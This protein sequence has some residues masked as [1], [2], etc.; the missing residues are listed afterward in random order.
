MSKPKHRSYDARTLRYVSGQLAYAGQISERYGDSP[1]R[2]ELRHWSE[3][4]R[5]EAN[6]IDAQRRRD[7]RLR[8]PQQKD[9]D[10]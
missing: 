9:A 3:E 2:R 8:S 1:E 6:R 5:L 4:Y 10:R 7:A